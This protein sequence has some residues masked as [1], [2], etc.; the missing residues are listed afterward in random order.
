[1]NELDEAANRAHEMLRFLREE[2][3]R[4]ARPYLKILADIEAMRPHVYYVDGK[5]IVPFLPGR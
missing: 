3:E 4:Q 5:T 1:M 2:Y